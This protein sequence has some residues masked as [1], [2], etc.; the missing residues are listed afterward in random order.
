[1]MQKQRLY[2]FKTKHKPCD[3]EL[4]LKLCRKILNKT[5]H[6]KCLWTKIDE[7]LNWKTQVHDLASRLNRSNS[8]LLKRFVSSGILRSV[9]FAIFRSHINY[10]CVAWGLTIYPKLKVSI[11]QEKVLRIINFAPFNAHTSPLFKISN[12]WAVI[13]CAPTHTYPHPPTPSQKRS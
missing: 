10:I 3:M 7:N 5:N 8:L 12:I 1:M 13:N 4:R 11:L 6:V 2:S 9:C